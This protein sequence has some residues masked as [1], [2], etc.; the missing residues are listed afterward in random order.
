ML[1]QVSTGPQYLKS[2]SRTKDPI[3]QTL[4]DIHIDYTACIHSSVFTSMVQKAL[5][6]HVFVP[7]YGIYI[8]QHFGTGEGNNILEVKMCQISY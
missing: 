2:E 3:T 6:R 8:Q 1:L 5:Q 4:A 7:D